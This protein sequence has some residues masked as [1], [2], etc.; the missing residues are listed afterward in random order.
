M[1]SPVSPIMEPED[2][3]RQQELQIRRLK[4]E[5]D[6]AQEQCGRL[7]KALDEA[8]DTVRALRGEKQ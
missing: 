5:R 4:E 7:L 3:I 2:I 8:F 1:I 6:A